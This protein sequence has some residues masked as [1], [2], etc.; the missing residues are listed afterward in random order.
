MQN[1]VINLSS[2]GTETYTDTIGFQPGYTLYRSI[3][4]YRNEVSSFSVSGSS[5]E[6]HPHSYSIVEEWKPIGYTSTQGYVSKQVPVEGGYETINGISTTIVQQTYSPDYIYVLSGAIQQLEVDAQSKLY[7]MVRGSIDL[8]IDA[9]QAKQTAKMSNALQRFNDAF[10]DKDGKFGISKLLRAT[11]KG[12]LVKATIKELGGKWLEWTYGWKPL[13]QT[14]YDLSEETLRHNVNKISSFDAKVRYSSKRNYRNGYGPGISQS[15]WAISHSAYA[16]IHYKMRFELSG[17]NPVARLTSLNP[18]SIAWELLP[19]SF[20]VDWFLDIGSYLRNT[21][22]RFLYQALF[23]G[24]TRSLRFGEDMSGSLGQ[25]SITGSPP[26]TTSAH[27]KHRIRSRYLSREVLSQLP[28]PSVP[29]FRADLGS[30]RLLN[31]AALL[32]TFLRK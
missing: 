24:G 16:G 1:K 2:I 6:D 18:A 13:L 26:L 22:S 4:T 27:Y 20:V 15:Q 31:A 17:E 12:R 21:E 32:T 19:Y 3:P 28:T 14:V 23:R 7:D 5:K 8:S 30:G 9:F 10:T 25:S 11:R 29:K